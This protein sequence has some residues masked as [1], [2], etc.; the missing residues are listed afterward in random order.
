MTIEASN[1]TCRGRCGRGW[2]ALLLPLLWLLQLSMSTTLDD[3]LAATVGLA[4]AFV[5]VGEKS[6]PMEL[7]TTAT[8]SSAK[9][10]R[11]AFVGTRLLLL[12]LLQFSPLTD[13]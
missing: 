7:S 8:S 3:E 2:T 10:T 5:A 4:A 12:L 6:P 13:P 11:A 9:E 1:F